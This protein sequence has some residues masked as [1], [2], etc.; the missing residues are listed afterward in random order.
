M[1]CAKRDGVEAA[2][3]SMIRSL[4]GARTTN[5][6]G[7][8][9]ATGGRWNANLR[10]P[11]ATTS[12]TQT[13]ATT[14]SRPPWTRYANDARGDDRGR[15]FQGCSLRPESDG[16]RALSSSGVSFSTA[17]HRRAFWGGRLTAHCARGALG[18]AARRAG[19]SSR[20]ARHGCSV[21]IPSAPCAKWRSPAVGRAH[22]T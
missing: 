16:R 7:R 22:V 18:S 3:R 8:N 5:A 15:R 17:R 4:L 11:Q 19:R 20:P 2:G 1:Q 9:V 6:I 21:R 12:N 14:G 13:A 10:A